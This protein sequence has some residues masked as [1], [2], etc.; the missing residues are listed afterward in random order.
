MAGE[1]S[2][3]A[4][5]V[6][7]IPERVVFNKVIPEERNREVEK[8]RNSAVKKEKYWAWKLLE[9]GIEHSLGIKFSDVEFE[10]D[11]NGK[12]TCPDCYFSI[13]HSSGVVAVAI[14]DKPVGIDIENASRFFAKYEKQKSVVTLLKYMLAEG[15]SGKTAKDA[16]DFWV[17]K[18]S[19]FKMQSEKLF[20]PQKINTNDYNFKTFELDFSEEQFYMAL[21]TENPLRCEMLMYDGKSFTPQN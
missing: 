17:K 7:K 19:A 10:K 20:S 5:Y 11:E 14:S 13:T 18:E 8:N 12:W 9:A 15:E 16:L 4:V 21:C 3:L 1:E 6:S 2:V